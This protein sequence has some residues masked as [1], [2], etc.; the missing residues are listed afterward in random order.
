M[1]PADN[2]EAD[3][4]DTI[5]ICG[6]GWQQKISD[7]EITSIYYKPITVG[8]KPTLAPGEADISKAVAISGDCITQNVD[9]SITGVNAQGVRIPIGSDYKT[10]DTIKVTV[11]GSATHDVRLWISN[12][13]L[14]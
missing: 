1:N 14:D 5:T 8:P 7:L 9:G 3:T 12:G 13:R 4:F 10:G 11:Y 6:A 2:A